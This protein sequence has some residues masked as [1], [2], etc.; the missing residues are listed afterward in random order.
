MNGLNVPPAVAIAQAAKVN[1]QIFLEQ[2]RMNVAKDL[3]MMFLGKQLQSLEPK[4]P[5]QEGIH[6]ASG[7]GG[8]RDAVAIATEAVDHANAL[9]EALGFTVRKPAEDG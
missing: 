6:R 7:A 9:M 1:R 4:G 5:W 8:P 2:L 3:Q